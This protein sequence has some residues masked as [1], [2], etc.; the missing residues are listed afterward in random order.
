M[1]V[2]IPSWKG[3]ILRGKGRPIVKY[4]HSA[5]TYAKTADPIE[6]LIRFLAR[7]RPRNHLLDGGPDP[8]WELAVLAE[9]APIV[10]YRDFLP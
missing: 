4:V 1:G 10:K 9:R 6:M 5:V 7:M 8:P 3:T 2:Q